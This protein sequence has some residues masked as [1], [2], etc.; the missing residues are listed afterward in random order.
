MEKNIKI[1]LI[2]CVIIG[3]FF[4]L[5]APTD[6]PVGSI[7]KIEP[8]K[9]L[10]AV[11]L[12][13]NQEHIIRSRFLFEAFM[14][15]FNREKRVISTDYYFDS[16]LPVY[17][18]ARR[19][20]HGENH[21]APLV[22]TIPEGFTNTQIAETVSV[23]LPNFNKANFLTTA[24]DKEGYLFPDTYYFLIDDTESEVIN[25]MSQNYEKKIN[26]IRP[27]I[28][29]SGKTENQIITMASIIEKEAKGNV[30]GQTDREV[31]A[32]ILWKRISLGMPLQVDAA[33]ETY[34]TKGLPKTPI[35]NPGMAAILAALNPTASPYLYYL[36]DKGGVIH[37]AKTFAEHEA[38]IK[39]YLDNE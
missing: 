37:Y 8:G 26:P 6:F 14:I 27:K 3:A 21:I 32:G 10:R 36:H 22:V 9:S 4:F 5:N 38:N 1:I 35:S 39:K 25:V 13:L 18:I 15:L 7:V 16:S 17:E 30:G 34:K 12:Q 24:L 19:I 11:S 29:A 23:K 20:A 28:T 33:P 2:V 31:I